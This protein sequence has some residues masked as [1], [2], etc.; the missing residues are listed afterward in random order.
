M[1]FVSSSNNNTSTTN[2]AV[3]TANRVSNASTQVNTAY[4]TNIDNLSDVVICLFFASQPNNPQLVHEDLEQ[5][6]LDDMEEM[7]LRWQMAKLTMRA[8]KFLKKTGRKLI[9]NGNETI[10][11]DKSNLE[12]YNCNKSGHFDGECRTPRNQDNKYKE[13]SRR[14]VPME[15]SASIT[16]VSCDVLVDMTRVI[17]QRKDLI[18]HS[19]LSHLQVLTQR[20]RLLNYNAV[21]PPYTGNFMPLT[22][23]LSYTGLDEFVNKHIVKN[24]KAKS[25]EE[26]PKVVRK[27]DEALIIKEWVSDNEKKEVS[28]SK[29]EKK[30][31]RPSIAK[32]E[33]VKPKQ[34]EKTARKTVKKVEQHRENTHSPRGI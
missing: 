32:I 28:Q 25:C 26:K 34:Q 19:W 11:F 6:H 3:N 14:S 33:F 2:R 23:D 8:R 22:P 24:C 10:G 4:S 18:M 30:T 13:N 31:V 1:T 27:N 12:C 7:D 29:V 16:L 21:P 5:I 15:T 9:V 20:L 17:S